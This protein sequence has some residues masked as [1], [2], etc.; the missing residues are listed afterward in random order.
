MQLAGG[1]E[2]PMP[3]TGEL[4]IPKTMPMRVASLSGTYTGTTCLQ[5]LFFQEDG[6]LLKPVSYTP[7]PA[8]ICILLPAQRSCATSFL[9]SQLCSFGLLQ[10]SSS[11][12]H[13][14]F[15]LHARGV[16]P[17]ANWLPNAMIIFISLL[18]MVVPQNKGTP[19]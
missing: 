2:V 12:K 6:L 17:Y 15:E 19:I 14:P 4:A 11:Q 8:K 18:H 5:V 1:R 7:K 10:T 9:E 13:L 16:V 3:F